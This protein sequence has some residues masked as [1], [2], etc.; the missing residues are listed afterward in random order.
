M[1][2]DAPAPW[3]RA[4]KHPAKPAI[5]RGSGSF[6]EKSGDQPATGREGAGHEPRHS[7]MEAALFATHESSEIFV[8][9]PSSP[10]TWSSKGSAAFSGAGTSRRDER[11]PGSNRA[12]LTGVAEETVETEG[13]TLNLAPAG[14]T[15]RGLESGTIDLMSS[16]LV[17]QHSLDPSTTDSNSNVDA[18]AL[19]PIANIS[20][21]ANVA[22][23]E[24]IRTV[25]TT[26]TTSI[27]S[28]Q[29]TLS[30]RTLTGSN[31]ATS[32]TTGNNPSTTHSQP[33]SD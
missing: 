2:A 14:V 9:A 12:A 31:T 7:S 28:V 26:T 8:D 25:Q 32:I 17:V 15:G 5:A 23:P 27:A 22:Q 6:S 16:N 1:A 4:G 20:N 24:N 3:G 29:H 18:M 30:D 11:S 21:L 33:G 10:P 13:S 19:G